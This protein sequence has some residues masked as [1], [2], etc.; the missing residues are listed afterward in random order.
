MLLRRSL[1]LPRLS[2]NTLVSLLDR[3]VHVTASAPR[4]LS[5]EE[6][7][8]ELD[9]LVW[10]RRHV[11]IEGRIHAG[12]V[13]IGFDDRAPL[14]RSS[15]RL[16]VCLP[17]PQGSAGLTLKLCSSCKMQTTR[18]SAPHRVTE[19]IAQLTALPAAFGEVWQARKAILLF[20]LTGDQTVA[21][22]LRRQFGL[23][24]VAD[25]AFA[26]PD[27]LFAGAPRDPSTPPVTII[28]PVFNAADDTARLLSVLPE[29]LTGDVRLVLIDDGST[30]KRIGRL[31]D[32][33]A[34]DHPQTAVIKNTGNIGFIG[35]VNAGLDALREG[36]HAIILNTD[37]LPPPGWVPRLMAPIVC[38]G[39]V[40]SVTPLSNNA[41]ILS[42]PHPGIETNPGKEMVAAIDKIAAELAPPEGSLPTGVGFCMA[43]NRAFI[44]RIGRFDP[45]FGRGYGEE[46]DWCRRAIEIGGRHVVANLFVG[47]RGGASFGAEQKAAR[48]RAASR[49]IRDRYPTYDG[50]VQN[51]IKRDDLG[52]HRLALAL[53]WLGF[54]S[55]DAVP[56]FVGHSLG[57]GAEAAL[58]RKVAAM[59]ANRP[60]ILI[61]RVG[62]PR[63]WRVELHGQGFK[64]AGDVANDIL[65]FQ[66]L[67]AV[68]NRH[69][70]YSCG[71]GAFDPV[72]VPRTIPKLATSGL[73]VQMHDFFPISP[74][75]NL[76]DKAGC[77]TG[78]PDLNTSDPAHRLKGGLDH[79]AVSHREWRALWG[80]V[81]NAADQITVFA[82]SGRDL[83]NEAYP[84]A[85][86]K[87]VLHPH[88]LP[89]LP[90]LVA[91]GG[92]SLGV[93]GGINHAKGG[94]VLV[95]LA[96]HMN[97]R[98][99]V[100]GE[101]D[102][103]FRLNKPHVVHGRY[104]QT[105]ISDLARRYDIGLWLIP[106]V[107]PETFSFAT[108]EALATGLPV[109]SFNLGAQADAL[110]DAPAGHVLDID[111]YDT[112]G[113]VAHIKTLWPE[114]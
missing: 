69:V 87:A 1:S 43:L 11:T 49:I 34:K 58:Q 75:W 82:P 83:L 44:D 67:A 61:L 80:K 2:R 84:Q 70:I 9:K 100:I 112:T 7:I 71:V 107:C 90:Q 10:Q 81:I 28:V 60:G 31:V 74:S 93:L 23:T 40:A 12:S 63:A 78:V 56:V 45:V 29:A 76:L 85:A 68:P 89:A 48:V 86:P 96:K 111:P 99:V 36:D 92:K 33:F 30:D 19:S 65:L 88:C 51:W 13:E 6:S 46:V 42:V 59:L 64:L 57:G 114:T 98:I 22:C 38:D 25:K 5:V 54:V 27:T 108:H 105:Q 94:Q 110:R 18:L 79:S 47:H 55:R 53:A 4:R 66:L 20:L 113:L 106:S 104:D 3:R 102:G 77:F 97:R 17:R 62:G 21:A 26:V 8:F 16:T 15:D 50:E 109:L 91:L 41:E 35:S 14:A 103:Q 73:E 24:D 52:A 95:D 101:M 32:Q 39:T 37:T 72:A